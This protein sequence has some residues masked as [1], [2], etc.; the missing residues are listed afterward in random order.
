MLTTCTSRKVLKHEGSH[1]AK[2]VGFGCTCEASLAAFVYLGI[3]QSASLF[4][5][6]GLRVQLRAMKEASGGLGWQR[7]GMMLTQ[8]LHDKSQNSDLLRVCILAGNDVVI[9]TSRRTIYQ[10][11][12]SP[13]LLRRQVA[14]A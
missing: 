2:C 14:Q 11:K 8:C 7:D 1:A 6:R 10:A 3:A 4:V 13:T 12:T 5:A 9:P